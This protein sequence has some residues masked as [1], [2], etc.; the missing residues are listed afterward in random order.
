[1]YLF[2]VQLEK[3]LHERKKLVLVFLPEKTDSIISKQR[4]Q[5]INW[6]MMAEN[7]ATSG[8]TD[9]QWSRLS[10]S[11]F[12]HRRGA[13]FRLKPTVLSLWRVKQ[14]TKYDKRVEAAA[15]MVK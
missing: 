8:R 14:A 10:V 6:N 1:M 5:K 9:D 13:S 12:H 4:V 2:S 11:G 15:R 3:K 7:D